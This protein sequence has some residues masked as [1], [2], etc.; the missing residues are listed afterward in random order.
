M[1]TVRFTLVAGLALG[2]L[3][4]VAQAQ[5]APDTP[6]AAS[7]QPSVQAISGVIKDSKSKQPIIGAVVTAKSGTTAITD[8]KGAFTL[9]VLPTDTINIDA[10]GFEQ[11]IAGPAL[12]GTD[13]IIPISPLALIGDEVVQIKGRAPVPVSGGARL[14]RQELATVPGTG[15]DLLASLDVMPGVSLPVGPGG[16]QGIIIRGSAPQDSRFLL[17]GFDIPQLYHLFNRSIIP[18]QAVANLEFQPGAFD[19]KFGRASS[20]IISVTSRGGNDKTEAV[21]EVSLIDAYVLASGPINNKARYL[22]SFRRS[23]VDAWL[24][25]VVPKDAGLLTA[26]RYYDG[27]A[28]IDWNN[29]AHWRTALTVVGSDD[30]TKLVRNDDQTDKEFGFS[31]NTGFVRGIAAAYWTGP[32]GLTLDLGVSALTQRISF[33]VGE[34]YLNI[35]SMAF[36]TRAEL[37]KRVESFGGLQD[38][39]FRVGG[40]IEPKRTKLDLYLRRS[41]SKPQQDFMEDSTPRNRFNGTVNI[42][43]LG[44]WATMEAGLSKTIRF[45]AGF[46]FDAFVRNAAYEVQPRGDITWKPTDKTKFR[47]AAGRYTRPPEYR[48]ELL[49]NDIG[50]ES[51]VQTAFGVE[52]KIGNDISIQGTLY[53]TERSG[54]VKRNTVGVYENQGRGRTFGAEVLATYRNDQVFAW[55]AYSLARSTQR[56]TASGEDYLFDFDQTNDLV[57]ASTYKTRNGKWQFGARFNYSTGKPFTPITGAIFNS[58]IDGYI[59][60]NGDINSERFRAAHQL[61]LRIDHIWKLKDW[62]LSAFLDINNAYANAPVIQNQYNYDF[63]QRA[64]VEGLP[65]LPSIGIKGEL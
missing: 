41:D 2:L 59:P 35:R 25:S 14:S 16:G 60:I 49:N 22:A 23:Y 9:N 58:D 40:E 17:D 61:D 65:I 30:L 51:S 39:A 63:S 21:S 43:D 55:L 4:P 34:Q 38:V 48:D 52:Q 37:A 8:D 46:R 24:P 31:A 3:T 47:L 18:T 28:R 50:P 13:L 45:T 32:K 5:D 6:P 53:D 1:Q 44:T 64:E 26:P 36:S 20:G 27:I 19:V 7:P 33:S 54:L 15:G 11:A 10:D 56:D 29:S 42:Q 62:S 57:I 12:S